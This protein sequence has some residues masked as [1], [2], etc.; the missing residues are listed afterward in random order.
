MRRTRLVL[1]SIP[2]SR[3]AVASIAAGQSPRATRSPQHDEPPLG[4]APSGAD[5]HCHHVIVGHLVH[6]TWDRSA[7]SPHLYKR[8]YPGLQTFA[9]RWWS[10]CRPHLRI[11]PGDEVYGTRGG[12]IVPSRASEN[13]RDSCALVYWRYWCCRQSQWW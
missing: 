9:F 8:R 11:R 7:A 4:P 2:L 5:V 13:D 6:H 1:A 3:P 12:R 10:Y